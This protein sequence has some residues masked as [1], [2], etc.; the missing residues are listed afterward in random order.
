M[1]DLFN[2]KSIKITR[3]E[4]D[5]LT[6]IV[7]DLQIECL[8]NDID[9]LNRDIEKST[10]KIDDNQTIADSI[11]EL[12]DLLY[13]IKE[14]T[15]QTVKNLILQSI[16]IETEENVQE[17]IAFL[18][19][20]IS[21]DILLHPYI[22][23]L[24][25][26][27]NEK[28]DES[29]HLEILLPFITQKLIYCLKNDVNVCEQNLEN[30]TKKKAKKKSNSN[31]VITTKTAKTHIS[32]KNQYIYAFIYKFYK[33]RIIEKNTLIESL[34][35]YNFANEYINLWFLPLFAEIDEKNIN[36]ILLSNAKN[37]NQYINDFILSYLPDEMDAYEKMLDNGEPD[38]W[39]IKALRND[40]VDTVQRQISHVFSKSK[41]NEIT[42]PFNVFDYYQF[43]KLN[44]LN[45]AAVY[46]SLKCF[47]YLLLNDHHID[48]ET[49]D[50][51]I[52]GG[53]IEIIKL[54]DQSIKINKKEKQNDILYAIRKHKNDLFDWLIEKIPNESLLMD[55]IA[56]ES[57]LHGNA[58]CLTAII[59][60]GFDIT[61]D[62]YTNI[63][64][65]ASKK[66]FF[67]FIK[68]FKEIIINKRNWTRKETKDKIDLNSVYF[69]NLS[70]FKLFI[71]DIWSDSI[72][73]YNIIK[74]I[75]FAVKN[76]YKSIVDYYLN[77]IIEDEYDISKS[78]NKILKAAIHRNDNNSFH[79]L[80]QIVYP[81]DL[82][83]NINFGYLLQKSI[84]HDNFEA[85]REITDIIQ[86]EN[87]FFD[88]SDGFNE[89]A[90]LGS[91]EICQYFLDKKVKIN[92]DSLVDKCKN[93]GLLNRNIYSIILNKIN[94]KLKTKFLFSVRHAI[95]KKNYELVDYLFQ[96]NAKCDDAL[97]LAVNKNDIDLVNI[98]LKYQHDPDLI[99]KVWDDGTALIKA[100]CNNNIEIV[101]RLFTVPGVN[102]S[103]YYSK[104][105]KIQFPLTIALK[106]KKIE[107]INA[108]L[109]FYGENL[110]N[111][112]LQL[113]KAMEIIFSIYMSAKRNDCF[114]PIINHF[115]E[116]KNINPNNLYSSNTKIEIYDIDDDKEEEEN[117]DNEDY[118]Q[119]HIKKIIENK[120]TISDIHKKYLVKVGNI[121]EDEENSLNYENKSANYEIKDV[122]Y[123]VSDVMTYLEMNYEKEKVDDVDDDDDDSHM[124]TYKYKKNKSQIPKNVEELG[125]INSFL[126]CACARNDV[127]MVKKLLNLDQIDVNL[128][129]LSN[130]DTPLITAIKNKNI[131]IVKLLIDHPK[132]NI[133]QRT[134]YNE[135]ALSIA[136]YNKLFAI[137]NTLLINER[138][139]PEDNQMSHI[140]SISN[141]NFKKTILSSTHIKLIDLDLSKIL[142]EA[143]KKND[144]NLIDIIIQNPF[145]D[146]NSISN[147]DIAFAIKNKS[148]TIFEKLIKLK[149]NDVNL[150]DAN[151]E[152]LLVNAVSVSNEKVIDYILSDEK[153]DSSKS[154]IVEAFVKTYSNPRV[155]KIHNLQK[156]M[157]KY[158]IINKYILLDLIESQTL[159]VIK[160]MIKLFEYDKKHDNLI[161]FNKLLPNGKS[162]FTSYTCYFNGLEQIFDFLLKNGIDPNMPDSNHLY[163]LEMAILDNSPEL[164]KYFI[165]TNKIDYSIKIP[166]LKKYRF[167]KERE[168]DEF[169]EEEEE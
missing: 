147:N 131:S 13:N 134:F 69:G 59:D 145:F 17:L 86:K 20:V 55:S 97:Y 98:V 87:P 116:I 7:D 40:D 122:D 91:N 50:L 114:M 18:L 117:S 92:F 133:N 106:K 112:N 162:Y 108:I 156:A 152:S 132:I 23:E 102:P 159:D 146:K 44:I 89:G 26:E 48:D 141:Y 73:K 136:V 34:H 5:S 19:E 150:H 67:R 27:L 6:E 115:L 119:L 68:F 45:Y 38:D 28:H 78:I 128:Y 54:A 47:K 29:N 105:K 100:V 123:F 61:D 11:D 81:L 165:N 25:N 125:S 109:D 94:T 84:K 142:H 62:R 41:K 144:I 71:N 164:V 82:S 36:Y 155:K 51:A 135:T 160:L 101:R 124:T 35:N 161:D 95:K 4:I 104:G 49:F 154:N 79:N 139:H 21:T 75:C 56:T 16:W 88:F 52:Y 110:Q 121:D 39:L 138:F 63:I 80:L 163:P 32:N 2:L 12:F 58:H 113:T 77:E 93:Y 57:A 24:I 14:K 111:Q 8:S 9:N 151:D 126:L 66:G 46:G 22:F 15:V 143:I 3:N 130:G 140:Y 127:N 31:V 148:F 70:I 169:E 153:F 118:M 158:K 64:Q 10:Q 43:R 30:N 37:D 149:D 166:I 85:I 83:F 53:N 42:I 137:A 99:N 65:R 76:N 120:M 90:L 72:C 167:K 129:S 168:L 157:I 103:I 60:K 96:K 1:C 107:I 74:H 33:N